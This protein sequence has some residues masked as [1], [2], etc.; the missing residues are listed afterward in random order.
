MSMVIFRC[1]IQIYLPLEDGFYDWWVEAQDR[2]NLIEFSDTNS[3]GVD[4]SP[5]DISHI[6]IELIDEGS[7]S[8]SID[9]DFFDAASGVQRCIFLL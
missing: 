1:A 2:A 8:P 3:F 4:A 5:P 7:T 9:A 6:P